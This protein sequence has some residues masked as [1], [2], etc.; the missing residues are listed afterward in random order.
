MPFINRAQVSDTTGKY[1]VSTALPAAAS[2]YHASIRHAD[3]PPFTFSLPYAAPIGS[4]VYVNGMRL[5]A[6]GRVYTWDFDVQGLPPNGPVGNAGLA[7]TQDGALITTGAAVVG[8][9]AGWPVAANGFVVMEAATVTLPGAFTFQ[10]STTAEQVTFLWT[11]STGAAT[12]EIYLDGVLKSAVAAPT[13]TT[14]IPVSSLAPGNLTMF[15]VN[16]AG[17]TP[18]TSNPVPLT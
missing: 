16:S 2:P 9:V 6:N 3:T 4:D 18:S 5:T 14:I 13:L 15:A 17:S 10:I 8:W 11:A 7:L 1:Q 12:Y